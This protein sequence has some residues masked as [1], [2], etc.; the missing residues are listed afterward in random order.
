[1]K[2]RHAILEAKNHG[3]KE[4]HFWFT[5]VIPYVLYPRIPGNPMGII[6]QRL[7]C[8]IFEMDKSPMI[9]SE[10]NDQSIV[11]HWLD[12]SCTLSMEP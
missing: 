7:K 9:V 8:E 6:L 11:H 4:E 2:F 10:I 5:Q 12:K 1:M 3:P